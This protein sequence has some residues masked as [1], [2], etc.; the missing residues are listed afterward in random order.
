[1]RGVGTQMTCFVNINQAGVL[2]DQTFCCVLYL[3][4]FVEGQ[5]VFYE[6]ADGG[7]AVFIKS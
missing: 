2:R 3:V 4:E 5:V 7:G 6:V 1:M